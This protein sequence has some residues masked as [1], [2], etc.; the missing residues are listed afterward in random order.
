MERKQLRDN[1]AVT[2][3]PQNGIFTHFDSKLSKMMV[4]YVIYCFKI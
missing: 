2:Q 4:H 3:T 1:D